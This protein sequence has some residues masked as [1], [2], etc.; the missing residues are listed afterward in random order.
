MINAICWSFRLYNLSIQSLD[1]DNKYTSTYIQMSQFVFELILSRLAARIS[2][3]CL[4]Q[5]L[6]MALYPV[7]SSRVVQINIY[8]IFTKLCK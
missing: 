6:P 8:R 1:H 3:S 4:L 2:I 7:V 5:S